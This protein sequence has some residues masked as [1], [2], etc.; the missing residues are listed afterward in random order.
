MKSRSR[1]RV[2]CLFHPFVGVAV[3]LEV[4]GFAVFRVLAHDVENRAYLVLAL[5]D[6]CIYAL[7]EV[8]KSL[9]NGGVEHNHCACA[10]G[11][12]TYGAELETVA[13]EC[14]R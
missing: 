6:E 11:F 7:L 10:V 3:A 14:E 2:V 9:G 5:L 1:V 12:G 8:G 4:Y 13:G